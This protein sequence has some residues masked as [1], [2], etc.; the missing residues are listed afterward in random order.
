VAS[1][2]AS[3]LL[4][5]G[6]ARDQLIEE[7]KESGVL[8]VAQVSGTSLLAAIIYDTTLLTLPYGYSCSICMWTTF[9]RMTR[10]LGTLLEGVIRDENHG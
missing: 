3:L 4:C 2:M 5:S 10:Q 8:Q 9:H 1:I 6:L 7:E